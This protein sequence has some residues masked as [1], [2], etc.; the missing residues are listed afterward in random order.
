M[1]GV[2]EQITDGVGNVILTQYEIVRPDRLRYRT[3]AGTEAII[4]GT[5]RYLRERGGA[6]VTDTIAQPL[7]LQGP[8]LSLLTDPR[9]V[10]LGREENCGGEVCQVVLWE[11]ADGSASFAVRVGATS[12]Q[13]Y[14]LL[15]VAPSHYMTSRPFD[16]NAPISIEPP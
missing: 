13:V 9:A 3:S 12:N 2:N 10:E 14:G 5:T 7:I 16:F 15:M 4:M 11:L 6:W 8:Y 1:A